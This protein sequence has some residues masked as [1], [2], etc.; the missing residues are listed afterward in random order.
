MS[1]S[2]MAQWSHGW[3][4]FDHFAQGLV[5]ENEGRLARGRLA[6]AMLDDFG[7]SAAN[8]DREALDQECA[9]ARFRQRPVNQ[10]RRMRCSGT[11]RQRFHSDLDEHGAW[12]AISIRGPARVAMVK[13]RDSAE[14]QAT[15][16]VLERCSKRLHVLGSWPCSL[17]GTTRPERHVE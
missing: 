17:T 5:A 3:R 7:V 11:D 1:H 15:A 9:V 4:G 12:A 14:M 8:A 6:T 13:N 16:A 10:L 2:P